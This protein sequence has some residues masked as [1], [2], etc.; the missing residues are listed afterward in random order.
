[1][2]H[3]SDRLAAVR[4]RAL[5]AYSLRAGT[6]NGLRIV[7]VTKGRSLASVEEVVQAGALEIGENYL[8]E[9]LKK[10]VFRLR[11][12][13]GILVR[14]IG[15]IQ[16]NKLSRVMREFD[17]LDSLEERLLSE[18]APATLSGEVRI[19]EFLLEI[20][21]GGEQQ[22]G[23]ITLERVREL[24][25]GRKQPLPSFVSGFMAVVPLEATMGERTTLYESVYEV[26]REVQERDASPAFT[27][28]SMGTSD[29]YELAITCG[30]NMV[31]V[32]TALF[33]PR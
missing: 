19:K 8:Q 4:E 22:K 27:I 15:R 32:G 7:C 12:Q 6:D 33:G 14:F 26:F 1:M 16:S 31:R 11:D 24:F 25:A 3:L 9:A 10:G 30:A 5:Y 21:A 29:D 28:L 2:G 20:N 17:A 13:Y 23:G 18:L